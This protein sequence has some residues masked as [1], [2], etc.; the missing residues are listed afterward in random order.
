MTDIAYPLQIAAYWGNDFDPEDT[1]QELTFLSQE[2]HL[3]YL[4][5]VDQADGWMD[6]RFL[7]HGSFKVNKEGG[8]VEG[9]PRKPSTNTQRFVLWGDSPEPGSKA[10]TF[11]F[12]SPD[13]AIAFQE[14]V[15][16]MVGWTKVFFV[17]SVDF[18]P[19]ENLVEAQAH[20]G[21]AA[22]QAIAKHLVAEAS[23]G[24]DGPYFVRADGA[25]VSSDWAP[26]EPIQNEPVPARVR[27]PG[28]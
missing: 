6:A 25:H 20:F 16:D 24:I 21:G 10:E 8:V 14:G 17:P 22:E 5:G 15:T 26:G 18:K 2:A 27:K 1:A 11:N 12:D 9:K 28:F 3:A 7:P 4:K 19:F 23:D 13:E